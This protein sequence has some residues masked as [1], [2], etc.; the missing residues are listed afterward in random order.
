MSIKVLFLRTDETTAWPIASLVE[1]GWADSRGVY[2][3]MARRVRTEEYDVM[4]ANRRA[5]RLAVH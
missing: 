4:G 2:D 1:Y 5:R 3:G